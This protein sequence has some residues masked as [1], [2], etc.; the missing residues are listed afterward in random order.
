[1]P[2]E[3]YNAY[4][5][6]LAKDPVSDWRETTQEMINDTWLNTSTVE[7]VEGQAYIGAKTFVKESVQWN[8]VL[9]P[10][11]GSSLGDE[12][13]KIIYKSL[14]DSELPPDILLSTQELLSCINGIELYKFT[15]IDGKPYL[16]RNSR[17]FLG[18]YYRFNNYIWLTINTNTTI[19]S[20]AT[21]IL[22]KCNNKL[23]WYNKDGKLCEWP[24]V[25]ERKL[26][27]TQFDMGSEGVGEVEASTLIKVQRNNETEQ[28]PYNQRFIFDGRAFQVN[29]INNHVSD[30]YIEL[31]LFET[32]I[33]ANDDTI[34]NIANG[35]I[36]KQSA[37]TQTRI[38]PE[39]NVLK[40]GKS[41]S[42]SVYK[43]VDGKLS[44]DEYSVSIIG[45][46]ENVN[47]RLAII[48]GNNFSIE[49]LLPI[50]VPLTI[51]CANK[52]DTTDVVS[53]NILLTGVW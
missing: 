49:C 10:K 33:Q 2:L 16:V 7:E 30:T 3:F 22:Q 52:S 4:M 19:G 1:M 28:I 51:I 36:E 11:T 12:Y 39:I 5:T 43:S 44:K 41:Q 17:R 8:S 31:Y 26:S 6:S 18:K 34:N 23:K 53:K 38:L 42:F 15:N 21:A 48:D 40:Q 32:Q 13:R 50:D 27:S 29:Q 46:V 9:D 37:T 20:N 45:A 14:F 35:K 24:C 25:F 47:Y